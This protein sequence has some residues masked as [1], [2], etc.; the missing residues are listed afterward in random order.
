M[1]VSVVANHYHIKICKFLRKKGEKRKNIRNQNRKK[2]KNNI[3][4]KNNN[5]C[6]SKKI[7]VDK[8]KSKQNQREMIKA[9]KYFE[10]KS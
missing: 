3:V 6:K 9:L 7:F 10:K 2:E 1:L 8:L 4:I 5:T